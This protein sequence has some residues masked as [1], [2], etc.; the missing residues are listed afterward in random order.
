M[1]VANKM[2]VAIAAVAKKPLDPLDQVIL[3]TAQ[4]VVV[5]A[6]DLEAAAQEREVKL[7]PK[8][9]ATPLLQL[10]CPNLLPT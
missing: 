9:K 6:V 5:A 7:K 4:V 2:I 10:R 1:I 3:V 8:L